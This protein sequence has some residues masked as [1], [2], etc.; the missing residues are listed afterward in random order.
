MLCLGFVNRDN[1]KKIFVIQCKFHTT[2]PKPPARYPR[3]QNQNP[4][5]DRKTKRS[6]YI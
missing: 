3:P 1:N 5:P 2:D 4:K 6:T